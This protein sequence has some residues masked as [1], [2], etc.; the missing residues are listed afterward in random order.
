M[1]QLSLLIFLTSSRFLLLVLVSLFILEIRYCN[2][3]FLE[4]LSQ[5]D[6]ASANSLVI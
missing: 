1:T 5:E 3:S 4:L 6:N 2:E